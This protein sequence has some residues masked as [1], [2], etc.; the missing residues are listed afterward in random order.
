MN[1][2]VRHR[3]IG[4]VLPVRLRPDVVP[5][6]HHRPAV[7]R[8]AG[9]N[10]VE[11]MDQPILIG[12]FAPHQ[13]GGGIDHDFNEVAVVRQPQVQDRQAGLGSNGQAHVV[14]RREALCAA[15]RLARQKTGNQL[16]HA[17]GLGVAQATQTGPLRLQA[18]PGGQVD[19]E[20]A[21]GFKRPDHGGREG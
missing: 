2:D 14:I 5:G 9:Q 15:D 16:A 7:H 18:L 4:R 6:Q 17:I 12:E 3:L 19:G 21:A 1:D 11:F 13:E 8:L 10:V 20:F